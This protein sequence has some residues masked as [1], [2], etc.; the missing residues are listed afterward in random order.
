M[1]ISIKKFVPFEQILYLLLLS[2]IIFDNLLNNIFTTSN[3]TMQ[4]TRLTFEII[5]REQKI[6]RMFLKYNETTE[7]VY[8]SFNVKITSFTIQLKISL[9]LM[10]K[11][12]LC[13]L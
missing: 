3:N 6:S 11:I 5:T 4:S 12:T 9:Y 10:H 2:T 13:I 1:K 8:V 7:V